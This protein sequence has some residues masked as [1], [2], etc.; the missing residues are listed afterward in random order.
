MVTFRKIVQD[1]IKTFLKNEQLSF[2]WIV[3]ES[4]KK[5][6]IWTSNL[7]IF[8]LVDKN[9]TLLIIY[10]YQVFCH[11]LKK[12]L[13]FFVALE[14]ENYFLCNFYERKPKKTQIWFKIDKISR[15]PNSRSWLETE[16]SQL[17]LSFFL[18]FV[19]KLL[20]S[21]KRFLTLSARWYHSMYVQLQW[22]QV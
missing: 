7:I 13:I 10:C 1:V 20:T 12:N 14:K 18:D 8:N 15:K 4:I 21:S 3:C 19:K 11:E 5:D 17:T 9:F 2:A 6:L 22:Q 16:Q